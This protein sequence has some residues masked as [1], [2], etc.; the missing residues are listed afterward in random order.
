[1]PVPQPSAV[2][3]DPAATIA[4]ACVSWRLYATSAKS[5]S[6]AVPKFGMPSELMLVALIVMATVPVVPAGRNTLSALLRG[7]AEPPVIEVWP[8]NT[9]PR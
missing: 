3:W 2:S 6:S 1:M 9:F 4:G 7:S 8:L 5:W